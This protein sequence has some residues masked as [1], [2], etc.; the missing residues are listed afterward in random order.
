MVFRGEAVRIEAGTEAAALAV[1]LGSERIGVADLTADLRPIIEAHLRQL[2]GRELSA[3]VLELAA[4][5]QCVVERVSVRN[6]RSRWG[7]CSRRGTIS[8]NWRLVQVPVF[9]RDYL[10][11]HELMHL[12]HMNHSRR[13]WQEVA[14]V[15]PDWLEAERWL[16]RNSD[17]LR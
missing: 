2:A 13:F 3:R 14:R 16:K 4:L 7:S 8:L 9:V 12:R 5:H 11:L 15:C 6:Q 1:R 17:L 10:I